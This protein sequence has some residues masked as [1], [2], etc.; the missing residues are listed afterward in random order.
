MIFILL[1][2]FYSGCL[3]GSFL[4]VVA[5]RIPIKKD[6]IRSRSECSHCQHLLNPVD[7][8]P[9]FTLLFRKNKCRYCEAS[10]PPYHSFFEC[11]VGVH[12]ILFFRFYPH[13]TFH[14]MVL[15]LMFLTLSLTDCLYGIVEPYILYFFTTILLCHSLFYHALTYQQFIVPVIV[16]LFFS[17][18][19]L[20]LPNTIGGGDIKLICYFSLFNGIYVTVW[21]VLLAS[22]SGILFIGFI[23]R[24]NKNTP[25]ILKFVPFLTLSFVILSLLGI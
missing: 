11:L 7:L 23:T 4:A 18:L 25:H 2:I 10:I 12:F 24:F 22:L 17:L 14:V 8:I 1:L 20:I 13:P 15:S 19:L 5:E 3:L 9:L 6:F 21:L 16:Y